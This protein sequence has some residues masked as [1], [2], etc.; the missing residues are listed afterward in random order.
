MPVEVLCHMIQTTNNIINDII[1][2]SSNYI[3]PLNTGKHW[4]TLFFHGH[5]KTIYYIDSFGSSMSKELTSILRNTFVQWSNVINTK[6]LQED[7]YQCGVW[8]CYFIAMI[9]E[10]LKNNSNYFIFIF[11]IFIF[12]T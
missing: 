3:L 1:Q 4:V 9:L 12:L 5:Q 10:Y 2:N 8:S 11:S 6:Q 7:S